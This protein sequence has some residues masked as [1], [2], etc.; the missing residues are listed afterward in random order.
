[1]NTL[2]VGGTSGLGLEIARSEAALGNNPVITG[3]HDPSVRFA[4]YRE[5]DLTTCNLPAKIGE[6]VTNL[7]T[8]NSLVYAAGYYQ[9]GRITD[10][11]DDEID[12]MI[13]V[14]GRGLI[15]FVKK[16]LE[17]QDRLDEL[18]TITSTSHWTP[19]EL[20]PVYNFVKAGA[21]HYSHG[22]SLDSRIGK[23]LVVGPSGMDTEFW[24]GV[25]KN[26]SNMMRPEWVA[27][28]VMELRQR[29]DKYIFTKILGANGN[30]PKRVEI[31]E[32]P[33]T[34][35]ESIGSL[36]RGQRERLGASA[37]ETAAQAG[38]SRYYLMCIEKGKPPRKNK[39]KEWR[40]SRKVLIRIS[41]ALGIEAGMV[42][43]A[44]G[45]TPTD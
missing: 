4:E 24:S 13:D 9:E 1:M 45:Y 3:R 32:P 34:K 39:S 10:L 36:V 22:Q 23:T 11:S 6:F 38:I 28:R 37:E 5:F 21:G 16:L 26:T 44:G 42:L 25:Q 29:D 40:P 7:P 14:G 2:I 20:E 12:S 15:F 8:I 31:V 35:A 27:Q 30:L 19:R 41:E 17:K 43:E 33:Q 18:V